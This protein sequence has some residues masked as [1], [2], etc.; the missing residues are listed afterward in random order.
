MDHYSACHKETEVC[1]N[2]NKDSSIPE[3]SDDTADVSDVTDSTPIL[4]FTP[5]TDVT[6]VTSV[7]EESVIKKGKLYNNLLYT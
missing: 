7:T 3:A 5:V 6:S 1:A 4:D 2:E